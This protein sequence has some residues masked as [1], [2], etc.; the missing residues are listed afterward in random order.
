VSLAVGG[1][2]A[3]LRQWQDMAAMSEAFDEVR[4]A[5]PGGV[6]YLLDAVTRWQTVTRTQARLR[7]SGPDRYR[8]EYSS[9]PDQLMPRL[10]VCDGERRWR[11]VQDRIVV[12]P[13]AP[14]REHGAFLAD[15]SCCSAAGCPAA[16]SSPT[17]AGPPASFASL[18]LPATRRRSW[19][20]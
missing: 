1:L 14:L 19:G 18:T 3:T 7:V 20:R 11:I 9:R 10:T 13:V 4:T 8:L 6:R 16:R 17:A 12:G 2:G 5:A 15:S